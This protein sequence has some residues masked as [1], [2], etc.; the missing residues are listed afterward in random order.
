ML[1]KEWVIEFYDPETC[2]N[3][4]L[5]QFYTETKKTHKIQ[6]CETFFF[7]F[8]LL[9]GQVF[10]E[11]KLLVRF[12]ILNHEIDFHYNINFKQ[13]TLLLPLFFVILC[14]TMDTEIQSLK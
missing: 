1:F 11:M 14:Y 3:S 2:I 6:S 9:V 4:H 10:W 12:W 13:Y 8:I 5:V 7:T